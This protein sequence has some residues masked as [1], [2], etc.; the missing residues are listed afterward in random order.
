[1]AKANL[2]SDKEQV[3]GIIIVGEGDK[4]LSYAVTMTSG[5]ELY[6]Y[7]LQFIIERDTGVLRRGNR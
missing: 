5:V 6:T 3:G 2:A 4:A 1:M 7:K